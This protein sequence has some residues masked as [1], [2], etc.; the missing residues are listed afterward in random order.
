MRRQQ[1][2]FCQSRESR[3]ITIEECGPESTGDMPSEL[4]ANR[5]TPNNDASGLSG[6]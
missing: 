3:H 2:G 5:L 1:N 4:S 6:F